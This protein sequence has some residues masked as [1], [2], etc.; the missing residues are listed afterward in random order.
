VRGRDSLHRAYRPGPLRRAS[1]VHSGG[2]AG[3]GLRDAG[4]GEGCHRVALRAADARPRWPR[5]APDRA[6]ENS[7]GGRHPDCLGARTTTGGWSGTLRQKWLTVAARHI[8]ARVPNPPA[9]VTEL[10]PQQRAV[11][12][13]GRALTSMSPEAA[14]KWPDRDRRMRSI[15]PPWG[16]G[17]GRCDSRRPRV[18]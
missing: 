7:A 12:P 17:A 4:S 1:S 2:A 15:R 10:V 18:P 5:L 6:A 11:A 14:T 9:T 8:S 13:P 3:L 16:H